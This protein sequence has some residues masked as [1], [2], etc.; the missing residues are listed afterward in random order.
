MTKA[1]LPVDI[2]VRVSR[3]G[4][5][6]PESLRSPIDQER[7]ARAFAHT[8]GLAVGEVLQDIDRPGANLE[9]PGLQKALQRIEAGTSGGIVVAYLSR[10]TRD[11]QTGL[12]L[13]AQITTAGGSVYAPNLPDYTTADG[14]MLTTIQLA[15]DTGYRMRKTRTHAARRMRAYRDAA[16]LLFQH[17]RERKIAG[18]H[19]CDDIQSGRNQIARSMRAYRHAIRQGMQKLLAAKTRRGAR[20]QKN[21][22]D[23]QYFSRWN[24]IIIKCCMFERTPTR[25]STRA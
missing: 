10:A 25:R 20:R 22:A 5:R 17:I 23:V 3:V 2:Y 24:A 11:T 8:K 14:R 16:P 21:C 15:I 18:L 1:A 13:L 6:D 7:E 9:R 12:E 19:D 4:S